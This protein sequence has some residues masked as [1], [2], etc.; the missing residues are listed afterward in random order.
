MHYFEHIGDC[1]VGAEAIF[2]T[3]SWEHMLSLPHVAGIIVAGC[4]HAG[5][6]AVCPPAEAHVPP[7]VEHHQSHGNGG[8]Y[9]PGNGWGTPAGAY[10][11]G[12]IEWTAGG[13]GYTPVVYVLPAECDTSKPGGGGPGDSGSP[14]GGVIC[15]TTVPEPAGW[16]MLLVGALGVVA[17][18][19]GRG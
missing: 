16:A 11:H 18:R 15:D 17:V 1:W 5:V 2:G 14:G 8:G 19:R 12:P 6:P 3:P 9:G 4:L 10:D 7:Q 13:H